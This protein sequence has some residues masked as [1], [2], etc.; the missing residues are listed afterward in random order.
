MMGIIIM[1]TARTG[2]LAYGHSHIILVLLRQERI[3]LPKRV[4]RIYEIDQ[5]DIPSEIFDR[6]ADCL[7]GDGLPE[8]SN[9]YYPRG[10]YPRSYEGVL[11]LLQDISGY[12]VRPVHLIGVAIGYPL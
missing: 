2:Y 8:T 10:T 11:V 7:A 1:L 6:T 9:M 5:P 3:S 12:N 4:Q